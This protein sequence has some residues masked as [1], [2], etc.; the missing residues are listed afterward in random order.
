VGFAPRLPLSSGH[1]HTKGFL[2]NK[3]LSFKTNF[4]I[5]KGK[6]EGANA[7]SETIIPLPLIK[8]KTNILGSFRGALAPLKKLSSP[9]PLLRGRGTKGDRVT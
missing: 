9:F 2:E 6:P 7:P 4:P 1:K 5:V 3:I 8:Q